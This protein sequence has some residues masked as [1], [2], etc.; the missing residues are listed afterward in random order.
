M[1][2]ASW[3]KAGLLGIVL[4]SNIANAPSKS[5]LSLLDKSKPH[6]SQFE[7]N[8]LLIANDNTYAFSNSLDVLVLEKEKWHSIFSNDS[9]NT[10]IYDTKTSEVLDVRPT[11]FAQTQEERNKIVLDSL[12]SIFLGGFLPKNEF[13]NLYEKVPTQHEINVDVLN[14]IHQEFL[15]IKMPEQKSKRPIGMVFGKKHKIT[16]GITRMSPFIEYYLKRLDEKNMHPNFLVIPLIESSYNHKAKSRANAVGAFQITYH[17]GKDLG[18]TISRQRGG[19]R[20][21]DYRRHPLEAFEKSSDYMK[22][23]E[24]I[25]PKFK[26]LAPIKYNYGPNRRVFKN[27]KTPKQALEVI[28]NLNKETKNYLPEILAVQEVLHDLIIAG[29]WNGF[30]PE[31]IKISK[32]EKTIGIKEVKEELNVEREDFLK[33]NPQYEFPNKNIDYKISKGRKIILPA[34]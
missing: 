7:K 10:I 2:T 13:L 17:T 11:V 34:D 27:L 32:L 22:R 5:H 20:V 23:L 9:T 14:K 6:Y 19:V 30:I 15:G 1:K 16:D 8:L 3:L 29:Y 25:T 12:Q 31:K 33:F 21:Y 18:L 24:D 28:A 26:F 4:S